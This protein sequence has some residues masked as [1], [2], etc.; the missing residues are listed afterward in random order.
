MQPT[1]DNRTSEA[2]KVWFAQREL[3]GS[4]LND[5]ESLGTRAVTARANR[6]FIM[7]ELSL[8][9]ELLTPSDFVCLFGKHA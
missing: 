2:D 3:V 5:Y 6:L 8:A 1:I 7:G 4:H 9:A